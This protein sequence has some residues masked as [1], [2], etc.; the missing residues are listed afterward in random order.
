MVALQIPLRAYIMRRPGNGL[1][2]E[3][4]K[5]NFLF[6]INFM[7]M[8]VLSVCMSMYHNMPGA[9]RSER[10]MDHLGRQS[11]TAAR[12]CMDAGN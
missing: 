8:D 12:H 5:G 1:L 3:V 6:K 9:K 2:S 7:C 11:Q 10:G 4:Q